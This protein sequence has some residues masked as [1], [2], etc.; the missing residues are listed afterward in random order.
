MTLQ[1]YCVFCAQFVTPQVI[2]GKTV[3]DLKTGKQSTTPSQGSGICPICC[4]P[5]VMQD[6]P[7]VSNTV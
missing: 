2:Q 1:P 4:N 5:I 6:K 7:E 3:I